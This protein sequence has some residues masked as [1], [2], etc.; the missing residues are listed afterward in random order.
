MIPDDRTYPEFDNM[1]GREIRVRLDALSNLLDR[2]LEAEYTKN[3][4]APQPR[5]PEP[6]RTDEKPTGRYDDFM[7]IAHRGWSGSYPENTLIGMREAIKIGCDMIEF[8]VALTRDRRP[9]IIHDNTLSRTTNGCG[10]VN[11]FTFSELREL[12]AGSWFHPKY[13]GAR[14]PSLDEILLISKGSGIMVNIEI[15]KECWDD[16]E[17]EDNIENQIME[18]I[19]RYQVRDRVVISSFRWGFIE[20]IHRADPGLKTA[21]LH[22]KDVGKLRPDE[23]KDR[24]GAYSFN[25]HSHE[26][27]RK[28]V[29]KCHEVDL[30]V[31]PFTINSYQDMETFIDMGV[32]GIFTNHPNRVMRFLREHGAH[33]RQLEQKEEHENSADVEAAIRRLEEDEVEKARKRARWR[34]KRMILEAKRARSR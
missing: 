25:P 17:L 32:D 19:E 29:D 8:D 11:E 1:T 5:E 14:L 7:V 27:T 28:F 30:K 13:S 22:Y 23:L 33:M 9:I 4:V 26:L 15:K 6:G 3:R 18:A 20:R 21:L 12:D 34:A 31:L 10:Q 2:E 16:E 24:Y